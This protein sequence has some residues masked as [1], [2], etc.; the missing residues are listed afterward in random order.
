MFTILYLLIALQKGTVACSEEL[1]RLIT[2]NKKTSEVIDDQNK[3]RTYQI[4][5]ITI[6]VIFI[7][8]VM[9][10]YIASCLLRILSFS[11]VLDS[12]V[13][14]Y[15]FTYIVILYSLF[16][17]FQQYLVT[18]ITLFALFPH[19]ESRHDLCECY[20]RLKSYL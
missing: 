20:Q 14:T 11:I 16:H 4:Q 19:T 7:I 5:D 12:I 10:C 18:S 8:Y 1:E 17:Y 6:A 15:Y 13:F 3:V 9:P 2:S